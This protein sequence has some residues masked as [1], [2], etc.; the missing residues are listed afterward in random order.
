MVTV[1]PEDGDIKTAKFIHNNISSFSPSLPIKLWYSNIYIN[2]YNDLEKGGFD[3]LFT[4]NFEEVV[5][6]YDDANSI[7]EIINIIKKLALTL[8]SSNKDKI[9]KYMINLCKISKIY[10]DKI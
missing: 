5:N 6:T 7:L 9:Y 3:S 10:H 8:S 4:K 1:F 2:Y